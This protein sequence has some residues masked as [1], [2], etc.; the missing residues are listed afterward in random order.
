M[1]EGDVP[2]SYQG[3]VAVEITRFSRRHG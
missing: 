3:A 1:L 2:P